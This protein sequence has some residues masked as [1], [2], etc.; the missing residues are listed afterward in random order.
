MVCR[1]TAKSWDTLPPS[2]LTAELHYPHLWKEHHHIHYLRVTRDK[3]EDATKNEEYPQQ[4]PTLSIDTFN[5]FKSAL[6]FFQDE[7]QNCFHNTLVC[8][9]TS[10]VQECADGHSQFLA[11]VFMTFTQEPF[12]L[13]N[14]QHQA[15]AWG[16][17]PV[18]HLQPMKIQ[19]E[20]AMAINSFPY[21]MASGSNLHKRNKKKS[22]IRLLK[23][24]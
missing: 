8:L 20:L 21:R 22:W 1:H 18:K 19:S 5:I 13:V 2:L 17:C 7:R 10:P 4:S 6:K 3:E 23:W 9:C 24:W 11:D 15:I 16:S 12:G 14:E